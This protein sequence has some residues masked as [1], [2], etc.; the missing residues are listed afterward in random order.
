MGEK[1]E[2]LLYEK[3]RFVVIDEWQ[4]VL[5]RINRCIVL[6]I[7]FKSI[8]LTT[9]T[10]KLCLRLPFHCWWCF[11]AMSNIILVSHVA[12][13]LDLVT[14]KLLCAIMVLI[15]LLMS[16]NVSVFNGK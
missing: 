4:H 14:G 7:L 16:S 12:S 13:P 11:G 5:C 3:G 10:V 6:R 9:S 2:N 15:I 8:S 1:Y